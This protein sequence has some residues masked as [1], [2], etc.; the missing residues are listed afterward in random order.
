MNRSGVIQKKTALTS[1]PIN[2]LRLTVPITIIGVH[3]PTPTHIQVSKVRGSLL[4]MTGHPSHNQATAI[5]IAII[6]A[7]GSS[8]N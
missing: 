5:Q 4:R 8:F 7:A 1:N 2:V 3:H 6:S